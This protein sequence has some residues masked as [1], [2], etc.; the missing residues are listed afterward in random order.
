MRQ[1][2]FSLF[3][4]LITIAVTG[5]VSAFA[6]PAYRSYIDTANMTIN[7]ANGIERPELDVE[8]I[9]DQV[10]E[11]VSSTKPEREAQAPWFVQ[12]LNG[13]FGQTLLDLAQG[14]SG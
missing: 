9:I 14:V 12:L 1:Q 11:G 3:E 10:V 13:T 2:G 5:I 7:V 4:L 8:H 6:I